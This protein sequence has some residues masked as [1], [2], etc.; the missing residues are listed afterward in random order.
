[1]LSD[2]G[3]QGY[4]DAAAKIKKAVTERWITAVNVDKKHG[5]WQY[6]MAYKPTEVMSLIDQ[7]MSAEA[8]YR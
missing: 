5:F 7:A 8:K 1:M 6:A 4:E 2:S 3:N